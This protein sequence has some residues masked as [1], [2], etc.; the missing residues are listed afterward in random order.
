LI[1]FQIAHVQGAEVGVDLLADFGT[2]VCKFTAAELRPV[3]AKL[4]DILNQQ[5][6]Q[7]LGNLPAFTDA[8]T[9]LDPKAFEVRG[10]AVAEVQQ[11]LRRDDGV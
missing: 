1:A 9:R 2:V 4:L 7:T 11:Q 3:V 6:E 8:L 10:C 5:S